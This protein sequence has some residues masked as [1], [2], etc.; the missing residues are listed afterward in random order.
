MNKCDFCIIA[1]N[2]NGKI[3]CPRRKGS[4]YYFCNDALEKMKQLKVR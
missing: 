2:K 3:T 1:K 4:D